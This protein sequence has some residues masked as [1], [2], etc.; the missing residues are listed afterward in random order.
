ML[1]TID[2]TAPVLRRGNPGP[3]GGS[4]RS[5]CYG[6]ACPP[7][8][9]RAARAVGRVVVGRGIRPTRPVELVVPF[10]AGGGTEM[11]TRHLS[12]GLARRLGQPFV[13][14]NRPGANT[15]LGTLSG[16]ALQARRIHAADRELRARGQSV[17]LPASSPSTPQT[18]LEP[19]TLIANSPTVLDG[20]GVAAGQLARANSSPMRRRGRASS[21]T[22]PTES[23]AS[24]HLARRAVPGA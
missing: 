11:V 21:T 14:L 5:P 8:W 6:A 12:E 10:P 15:N 3:G 23:A 20:A 4:L 22:P 13:V 1:R 24:P 7:G 2:R 16:R 19:I 9:M 17:A 18:D